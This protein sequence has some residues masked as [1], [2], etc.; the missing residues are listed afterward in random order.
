ML[1][2][3]GFLFPDAA[4]VGC[5]ERARRGHEAVVKLLLETGKADVDSKDTEDGRTPLSWAARS[6]HKAVVKLLLETGKVNVDS[7]SNSGKTP[8]SWAAGSGHEAV[9]KLLQSFIAT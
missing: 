2:R 5:T 7:K 8:L 1:E 9:V 3:K 4:V 6:G